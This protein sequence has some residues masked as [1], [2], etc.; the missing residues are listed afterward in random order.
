M[1]MEPQGAGERRTIQNKN[2]LLWNLEGGIGIKTGY[3]KA[4]GKCLV[5]AVENDTA[6]VVSVV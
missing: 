1:T 2:K 6:R 4:A 5:G 3:T